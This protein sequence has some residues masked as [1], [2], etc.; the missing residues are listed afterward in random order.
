MKE[1][2]PLKVNMIAYHKQYHIM[3]NYLIILVLYCTAD[4]ALINIKTK[5]SNCF[6][7]LLYD[8]LN[9]SNETHRCCYVEIFSISTAVPHKTCQQF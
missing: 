3:C 5:L 7:D 2:I 8:K 9:S 4:Y 6:I 1:R